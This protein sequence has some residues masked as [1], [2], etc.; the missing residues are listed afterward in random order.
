MRMKKMRMRKNNEFKARDIWILTFLA[1][2]FF[3][4]PFILFSPCFRTLVLAC[5]CTLSIIW[6]GSMTTSASGANIIEKAIVSF[7]S[8]LSQI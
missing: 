1:S 5:T 4:S 8:S 7:T 2:I 3:L 6:R